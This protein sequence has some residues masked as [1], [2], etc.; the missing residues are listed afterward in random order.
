MRD[1]SSAALKEKLHN[2]LYSY[3]KAVYNFASLLD[4]ERSL[5]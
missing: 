5:G 3:K 1:A 4:A 2:P